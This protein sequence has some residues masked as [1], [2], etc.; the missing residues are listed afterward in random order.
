MRGD[1]PLAA[2]A[3]PRIPLPILTISTLP[4]SP[5][6]CQA[7]GNC[8][9]GPTPPAFAIHLTASTMFALQ[10]ARATFVAKPTTA[11]RR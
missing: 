10:T 4:I 6:P 3:L 9:P 5:T 1:F 8:K 11:A 7:P 2:P